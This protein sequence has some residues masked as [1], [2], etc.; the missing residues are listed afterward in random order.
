M[1]SWGCLP[2][3]RLSFD[4]PLDELVHRRNDGLGPFSATRL[5]GLACSSTS[6]AAVAFSAK[7]SLSV[8]LESMCARSAENQAE[9]TN[10]GGLGGHR[11]AAPGGSVPDLSSHASRTLGLRVVVRELSKP[12]RKVKARALGGSSCPPI[13]RRRHLGI[14]RAQRRPDSAEYHTRIHR[15]RPA[16][17]TARRQPGRCSPSRLDE[18]ARTRRLGTKRR[19]WFHGRASPVSGGLRTC[20]HT[21]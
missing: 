10:S 8:M 7:M 13:F 20:K 11:V 4:C 1:R 18:R 17:P 15:T 5:P 12:P 16:I 19:R 3:D 2:L 21:G 14:G 9:I 6:E